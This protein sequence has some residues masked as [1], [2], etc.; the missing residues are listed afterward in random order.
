MVN[1]AAAVR[2]ALGSG[3][4]EAPDDDVKT[5]ELKSRHLVLTPHKRWLLPESPSWS[6]NP[7]SDNN[8][9]FQYHM[10]RWLDPLRRAS[11]RGDVEAARLWKKYA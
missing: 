5:E 8:W 4:T 6:E 10:L 9:Q 11:L 3:F 7:F 1:E 2:Q